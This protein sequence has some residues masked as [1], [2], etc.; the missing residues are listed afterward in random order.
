[1]EFMKAMEAKMETQI[2]SLASVMN[3]IEHERKAH[4]EEM[5]A[6]MDAWRG[7]TRACLEKESAPEETEVAAE[8]Q[9][10]P[11]GAMGEETIGATEDRSRNLRLAV[12]CRGQLKT[13]T[14]RDGR[15]RQE[16]A[17]AVG[18]PTRRTVPATRKGV[19]RKGPGIKSRRIVIKGRGKASGNE[20]RGKIMKR[21]R[22][23]DGK[24]THSEAISKSLCMEI[25]KLI[26]ESSVRLR[27]P[28]DELLWKRR[29]PPKRR[30]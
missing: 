1:M 14:K 15:L 18:R 20:M 4:H 28:G 8:P 27:E 29:P 19:L 26:F 22:R 5:M 9:E 21:R 3:A 23:L 10:V 6:K 16:C 12:G 2:G 25:T 17:P 30:R 13:R 11:E 24:K 7:V